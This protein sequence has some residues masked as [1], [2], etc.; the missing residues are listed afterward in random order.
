MAI[1]LVKI[2]PIRNDMRNPLSILK[3]KTK[4]VELGQSFVKAMLEFFNDLTVTTSKKTNSQR[5]AP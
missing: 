5:G 2:K 3:P 4:F 1:K